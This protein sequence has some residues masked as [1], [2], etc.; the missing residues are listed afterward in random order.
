MTDETLE[1]RVKKWLLSQG[2]PLEMR[3]AA[4]FVRAGFSVTQSDYY[5]DPRS[6]LPREID[7]NAHVQKLM[8]NTLFRLGA[9]VE[10]KAG[11]AKPWIVFAS[12]QIRLADRARIVQRAATRLGRYWLESVSLRED[13]CDRQIFKLPQRAGYGITAAF[14]EKL[15]IPYIALMA[16]ASAANA[17]VDETNKRKPHISVWF[18]IV[19]TEAPLFECWLTEQNEPQLKS[20]DRTVITWRNPVYRMPYCFI[21]VVQAAAM[22][23]FVAE[24]RDDFDFLINNTDAEAK[25]ALKRLR[26]DKLAGGAVRSIK[27]FPLS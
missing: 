3:V 27:H 12:E 13:V 17:E 7:I 8:G 25:D 14:T 10:C 19:V 26:L 5:T 2:Y 15:D 4:K 21:D 9:V 20:I 24:L 18:P 6:D 1:Q 23:A 22:E 11:E 16:A